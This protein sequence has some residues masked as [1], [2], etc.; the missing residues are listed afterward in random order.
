MGR[1]LLKQVALAL[2]KLPA[3]R[4]AGRQPAARRRVLHTAGGRGLE[5]Q[6]FIVLS[7]G[8][9]F[10]WGG[11]SRIRMRSFEVPSDPIHPFVA[12]QHVSLEFRFSAVFATV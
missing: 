1:N 2:E 5:L 4:R 6:K 9:P 7:W 3:R 11:L 8:P 10:Y 12:F